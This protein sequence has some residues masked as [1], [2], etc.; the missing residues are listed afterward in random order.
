MLKISEKKIGK[1]VAKCLN[2]ISKEGVIKLK[3]TL[4]PTKFILLCNA[5]LVTGF[6]R[7]EVVQLFSSF[8]TVAAVVM[9]IG[10]SYCF[11]SFENVDDSSNGYT[12]INGSFC[13]EKNMQPLYLCFI[14]ELDG[15][16]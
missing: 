13:L 10:K 4:N 16:N 12:T 1:K 2:S 9:I 8:G 5:G 11:V 7:E 3:P 6:T 15:L 14:E